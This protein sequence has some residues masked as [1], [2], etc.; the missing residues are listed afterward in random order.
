V[1]LGSQKGTS[2]ILNVMLEIITLIPIVIGIFLGIPVIL[3]Y[4][5]NFLIDFIDKRKSTIKE[6]T[7]KDETI[8]KV[9]VIDTSLKWMYLFFLFFLTSIYRPGQWQGLHSP[10]E[11]AILVTTLWLLFIFGIYKITLN[12]DRTITTYRLFKKDNIPIDEIISIK[13]TLRYYKITYKKGVFRFSDLLTG[14][15]GMVKSLLYSNPKII[16]QKFDTKDLKSD[17]MGLSLFANII[18]VGVSLCLILGLVVWYYI[19]N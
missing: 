11:V 10:V 3:M 8:L 17:P 16:Y 12:A 14:S 19:K 2:P 7:V 5:V 9:S 18:G 1:A 6:E 4:G 13:E 15:G